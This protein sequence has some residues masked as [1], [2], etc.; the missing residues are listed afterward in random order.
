MQKVAVVT[1]GAKRI[2]AEITR[3]LHA[4]G[5]DIALHYRNSAGDAASLSAEL[6]G[7]RAGSCHCF[8]AD[9]DTL[10][11]IEL[12]AEQIASRYDGIDVLVNN[13]SGFSPTPINDCSSA[14]FDAMVSS[15]LKG[16][17]F[18][19]QALMDRIKVAGGCIINI[20]DVHA[21][22]PLREFNVYGAA[23]AGL[24]SLTRS[25]A[26]E[27]APDIRVNAVA[28]GA[29]LWPQNDTAYDEASRMHTIENTPL[30]RLGEAS[31][32]ARTVCFLA[33]D[34]PFITGQI[35]TVDGGRS[36]I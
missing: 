12:M 18:L 33:M 13:A 21:E 16:H 1:G 8:C 34:A 28:P 14:Q 24:A 32:I 6:N 22:R 2:G 20:V 29:I 4:R 25:L 11:D 23:K 35:I 15:N 30:K 17:Y 19:V 27:L 10:P 5:Y 36:L 3:H 7:K 31:D 26:V 9:L